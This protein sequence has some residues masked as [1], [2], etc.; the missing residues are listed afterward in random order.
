MVQGDG[1]CSQLVL[2]WLCCSFLLTVFPCFSVGSF[3]WERV[4]MCVFPMGSSSSQTAPVRVPSPGSSPSGTGCSICD[5]PWGHRFCQ[6]T[7]SRVGSS[8][9]GSTGACFSIGCIFLQGRCVHCCSKRSSMGCRGT[10]CFTR[11]FTTGC[12]GLF[13]TNSL[14]LL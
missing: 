14:L 3:P 12:R 8:L 7:C 10:A 9:H 2:L 11:V 1:V 5:S 13:G 6:Q 4:L